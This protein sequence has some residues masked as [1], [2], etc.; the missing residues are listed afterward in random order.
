VAPGFHAPFQAEVAFL[1]DEP[2]RGPVTFSG[3]CAWD[4]PGV[5]LVHRWKAGLLLQDARGKGRTVKRVRYLVRDAGGRVAVSFLGGDPA[6]KVH[7][8]SLSALVFH[9][10]VG[11]LGDP[12]AATE[13]KVELEF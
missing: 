9:L 2:G 6:A 8:E 7:A 10:S 11:V 5:P 12:G 13:H 3:R 4:D 1:V